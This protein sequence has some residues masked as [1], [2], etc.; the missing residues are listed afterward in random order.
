MPLITIE[1]VSKSFGTKKVFENISLS[2]AQNQIYGVIGLTGAGK[3]TLFHLL[4]GQ[5]DPNTGNIKINGKAVNSSEVKRIAG[6]STQ[7]PSFYPQLTVLENLEFF[8]AL[9]DLTKKKTKERLDEVL[10]LTGLKKEK[11]TLAKNLSGGMRK[12]LDIACALIHDPQIIVL[13][14]PTA[15]LDPLMRKHIWAMLKEIKSQGKTIVL[16]SHYLDEIEHLCDEIA[17]IHNKKVLREGTLDEMKHIFSGERQIV[18]RTKTQDYQKIRDAF[19]KERLAIT[20]IREEQG[21]LIITTKKTQHLIRKALHILDNLDEDLISCD[22]RP[23]HLHEVFEQLTKG[24][25]Q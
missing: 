15:D 21:D 8:A 16:S 10:L 6:Y 7:E 23:P 11:H 9:Y 20:T 4:L 18:L 1:N 2:I 25:A 22:V 5:E 17:I 3:T 19:K 13:D 12:C 24:V 14:E